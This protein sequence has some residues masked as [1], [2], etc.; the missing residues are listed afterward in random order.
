[1]Q[2]KNLH[3]SEEIQ[4]GDLPRLNKVAP[5]DIVTISAEMAL[6]VA[7]ACDREMNL[8]WKALRLDYTLPKFDFVK[9]RIKN[10]RDARNFALR[11]QRPRHSRG[12]AGNCC[13]IL[14]TSDN[15]G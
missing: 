6:Y 15:L 10:P 3:V 8:G 9:H 7:A 14:W 5:C 13:P 1:V 2:A 12:I 4:F 11:A